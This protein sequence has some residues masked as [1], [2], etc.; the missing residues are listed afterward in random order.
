[1]DTIKE[2]KFKVGERVVWYLSQG[3]Q[4]VTISN[5]TITGSLEIN[6][7]KDAS[8]NPNGRGQSNTHGYLGKLTPEIELAF[9]RRRLIY[10]IRNTDYRKLKT[11]ELRR[12]D[13]ILRTSE[14]TKGEL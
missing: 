7:I 14:T 5:E 11:G 10:N 13:H 9:E 4:I 1:M 6:L 3:D 12:L 8:F 2:S